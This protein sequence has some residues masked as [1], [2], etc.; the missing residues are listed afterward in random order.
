[1]C[2][3]FPQTGSRLGSCNS[4][5]PNSEGGTTGRAWACPLA[6]DKIPTRPT[7]ALGHQRT[8]TLSA[9]KQHLPGQTLSG[10]F[11]TLL[12]LMSLPVS[13]AL[14]RNSK[15]PLLSECLQHQR[16]SGP[17]T[18]PSNQVAKA[19]STIAIAV[20]HDIAAGRRLQY[21]WKLR[22]G[23]LEMGVWHGAEQRTPPPSRGPWHA[24]DMRAVRWKSGKSCNLCPQSR[25]VN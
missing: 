11:C 7:P 17:S 22:A 5:Q 6:E 16:A 12:P 2:I 15:E 20:C 25:I 9:R 21:D 1:V 8:S 10:P 24:P 4:V 3:H 13:L 18:I 23:R 19:P 14:I